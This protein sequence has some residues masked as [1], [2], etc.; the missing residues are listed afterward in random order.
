MDLSLQDAFNAVIGGAGAIGGWFLKAIYAEIQALRK[1]DKALGE[2]V[3]ELQVVVAGDYVKKQDMQDM[4][5]ELM[6]VMLRI[7]GKLD[8]KADR[9]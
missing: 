7:E 1:E 5:N 3:Q 9:A 6:G 2:K 8:K 4:R